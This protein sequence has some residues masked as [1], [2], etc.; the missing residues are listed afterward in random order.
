M[1][2]F[3]EKVKNIFLVQPQWESKKPS[4]RFKKCRASRLHYPFLWAP[5]DRQRSHHCHETYSLR[6]AN[7]Y[8]AQ[9]QRRLSAVVI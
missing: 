8:L 3:P 4:V 5:I 1:H 9:T 6:P 2:A 7:P